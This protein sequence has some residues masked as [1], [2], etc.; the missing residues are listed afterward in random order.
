MDDTPNQVA[1]EP[2][3]SWSEICRQDALQ[4]RWVAIDGAIYEDASDRPSYGTVV[5]ADEDPAEL[6]ARLRESAFRN[7][8][9]HYVDQ[10]EDA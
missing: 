5:D 1:T 9:V 4:G 6:C 8:A 10:D 3:Q 2:R 7:C